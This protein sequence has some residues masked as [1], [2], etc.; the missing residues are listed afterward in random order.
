MATEKS[1]EKQAA[2]AEKSAAQQLQEMPKVKI[3]IPDDP[4]NP[5]DKVVPVGFNG[6]IYTIPRGVT[7]EVPQVIAEIWQ[8]SYERTRA[9]NQRIE[10]STSQEIKVM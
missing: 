6:V 4:Q 10:K 3:I 2:E 1:L 5:S 9:V 8:D 7:V